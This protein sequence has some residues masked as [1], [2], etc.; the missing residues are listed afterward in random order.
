MIKTRHEAG[1]SQK[2]LAER[3]GLQ[4]ANI[5]RNENRH[6]NPSLSALN[7]DSSGDGKEAGYHI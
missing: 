3:T 4:Q 7:R 1:L 6:G 5:S 2:D